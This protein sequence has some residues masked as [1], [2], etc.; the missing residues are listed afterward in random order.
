MSR[1]MLYKAIENRGI[2]QQFHTLDV[3]LSPVLV[4]ICDFFRNFTA[5][6]LFAKELPDEEWRIASRLRT[7]I[8]AANKLIPVAA[9]DVFI[10]Y[11]TR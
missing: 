8:P 10:V 4:Y 9:T 6:S 1:Y 11:A 5:V 7:A 2:I 3:P